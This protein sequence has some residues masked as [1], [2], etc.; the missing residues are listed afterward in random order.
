MLRKKAWFHILTDFSRI[1]SSDEKANGR[2]TAQRPHQHQHRAAE[3]SAQSRVRQAAARL[4]AREGGHLGDGR[5]L[6]ESLAASE[7]EGRRDLWPD[8]GRRRLLSL[9]AGG[10]QLP[11]ALRRPN[12]GPPTAAQPL[13]GPAGVQPRFLHPLPSRLAAPSDQLRQACERGQQRPVEALVG[14]RQHHLLPEREREN[15][16]TKS[17]NVTDR[18]LK[19]HWSRFPFALAG[20]SILLSVLL[21]WRNRHNVPV[22]L[23]KDWNY[24]VLLSMYTACIH[25]IRFTI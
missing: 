20:D 4:Q 15:E 2:E 24:Q 3:I 22:F 6:S 10:G 13:P 25:V 1:F 12:S 19:T 14:W 17:V 16:R 7:A 5:V 23:W 18:K 11:V 9:R 21:V 8:G